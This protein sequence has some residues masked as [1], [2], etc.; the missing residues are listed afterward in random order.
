MIET[1]AL[2]IG[3]GPT[4]LFQVF[5]LGLLGLQAEVVDVLPQAG[6][7]CIELYPDKPI[8]D[9]PAVPVCTGRELVDRLLAQIQ[10]FH[11]GLHFGQIVSTLQPQA[12]GRWQV[13]TSQGLQWLARS[14]FIAAG[15]GAFAPRRLKVAG[16]EA[17][18]GTQVFHQRQD[19]HRFVGQRLV[20]VGGDEAALTHALACAVA[21][22]MSHCAEGSVTLLHRRRVFQAPPELVARFEAA[23]DSGALHFVAGQ[24][25]GLVGLDEAGGHL[26][27]VR[28][29]QADGQ[30]GVLA[31]DALQVLLGLT[32]QLGPIADWGLA[33]ERK[34]VPVDP[35]TCATALP[36]VYAVGD[37]NQY[38]GKKRLIVCG[39]H[40]ATM[41]AHAE[42][43]RRH[44]GVAGPLLYSSASPVLQA[45]LGVGL[46]VAK[47]AS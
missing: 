31:L 6:G 17:H 41:A 8:Y 34:Q 5:Q 21:Q 26:Q 23:C 27:G 22:G 4:G 44:G 28:V 43:A 13:G 46:D 35:A 2:V 42:A 11:A 9:I 38:A 40:E 16:I 47:S 39:F 24:V 29:L 15:V 20:I 1:D 18:E 37:I 36:G 32:P 45:R 33:L 25:V 12:D 7:Q 14:V 30:P 19:P 10:P 3:A